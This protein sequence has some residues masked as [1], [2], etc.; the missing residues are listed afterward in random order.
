MSPALTFTLVLLAAYGLI[1]RLL[2]TLVALECR[3]VLP[4]VR[5]NADWLLRLCQLLAHEAA[6]VALLAFVGF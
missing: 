2:T 3:G 1:N 5:L 4:Q 6:H